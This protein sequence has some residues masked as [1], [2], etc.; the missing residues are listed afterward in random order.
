M[1]RG[2]LS[3]ASCTD[4]FGTYKGGILDCKSRKSPYGFHVDSR[5]C[6]TAER[7]ARAMRD[8][9]KGTRKAQ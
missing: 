4:S 6:V 5:Q 7:D 3:F 1:T 8:H 2:P 9:H